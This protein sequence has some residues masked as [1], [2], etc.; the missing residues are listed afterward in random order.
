[1]ILVEKYQNPVS[2]QIK[3]YLVELDNYI[4]LMIMI[5]CISNITFFNLIVVYAHFYL[6]MISI[7]I[8]NS[9][10]QLDSKC[11]LLYIDFIFTVL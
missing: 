11:F 1:M 7:C 3:K 2:V 10:K 5:C 6:C 9:L 4:I 8:Y